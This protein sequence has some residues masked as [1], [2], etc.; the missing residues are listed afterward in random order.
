MEGST[1]GN[2]ILEEDVQLEESGSDVWDNPQ[3]KARDEQKT[4]CLDNKGTVLD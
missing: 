4:S 1:R 3:K 2:E